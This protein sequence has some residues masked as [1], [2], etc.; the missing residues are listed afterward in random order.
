[1]MLDLRTLAAMVVVFGAGGAFGQQPP[2][3]L[4]ASDLPEDVL[5]LETLDLT[6]V[7]QGWGYARAAKSIEGKP[8]T[9]AGKVYEHGI[10]SHAVGEFIVDLKGAATRFA[11]SVGVDDDTNGKGSVRFVVVVDGQERARTRVL[12]AGDK[13]ANIDVDVTK[14]REL[15]LRIEDGGDGI[16]YDHADWADARLFLT[17]GLAAGVRPAALSIDAPVTI[18]M[19][20]PGPEPRINPPR[21][22]GGTPGY[23]FLFRVPAT[24]EG[25]LKFEAEGLPKGLTIDGATGIISGS[26]AEDGRAS[27][28]ISVTNARGKATA[29]LTIIGKRG[30]VALTP[31]MGWNSWNV[32]GTAVDDA[33][34]RA[35]ADAMVGSG[36][37]ACGYR[38]I[39]IDDAWE[40]Q[41]DK[42]GNIQSNE[43]FPDMKALADYVHAR[44]LKLGIYSSPGEK[45]CAG[46]E[47]SLGH[48][49]QDAR[50]YAAWGVDLLK[51]DWCS[52]A[53]VAPNPSDED[54]RRPYI[55]MRSALDACRRDIVLS[56]C[57]YGMGHVWTW[58]AEVGGNYWRT[59]DDISDTWQ[60]M[61]T[62]GFGQNDHA[63]FAEQNHWND[64]DMLVVGTLGWGPNLRPTRLKPQEQVTH[65]T[66]WTMLSA[67]MLIGCDL[68][69]I[70]DFTLALLTNPE[71]IEVGQDRL[72]Q[73]ARRVA[74]RAGLEVWAKKL[75]D[76]SVAVAAFNRTRRAGSISVGMAELGLTEK[77]RAVRN[78]WERREMGMVQDLR[79]DPPP[80]G[81]V[82]VRIGGDATD[83]GTGK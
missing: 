2:P 60:S 10:G 71:V 56:L 37:A 36:L 1:M 61:S 42:E 63:R 83:A 9:I 73:Q 64:P 8:I 41:R 5:W 54:L 65:I 14:A 6:A 44:G 21:I 38:Y 40:G 17:P 27:V 53:K 12:R 51:Y 57:Q 81:A 11:A 22:T 30:A 24:G 49:E 80:H 7:D 69:Q 43:K 34:V 68:S 70:D 25:P 32:W 23:P 82:M 67:P 79:F 75:A 31:P 26:I 48:E 29:P 16:N 77:P 15:V 33:K 28:T 46:L 72:G 76:G 13:A 66:L 59:T 18:S 78:L 45:T 35:A 50:Q 20:R 19:A 55:L 74:E 39:N 62:I 47:G 4:Q 52:Y 58:G 3:S